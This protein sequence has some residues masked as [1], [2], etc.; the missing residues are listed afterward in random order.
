MWP[1]ALQQ[2]QLKSDACWDSVVVHCYELA[3]DIWPKIRQNH[4][5]GL[6][7][8][9]Q[10]CLMNWTSTILGQSQLVKFRSGDRALLDKLCSRIR[11]RRTEAREKV[12]S[13]C[14]HD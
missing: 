12:A 6:E 11:V 3:E 1:N 14:L 10:F 13:H 8:V 9:H 7:N 5:L 4:I 2:G